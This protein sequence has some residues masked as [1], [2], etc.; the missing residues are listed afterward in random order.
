MSEKVGAVIER[1]AARIKDSHIFFR[2]NIPNKKLWNAV[3]A[4][5]NGA[6]E[7]DVLVLIDNTTFGSAKD[8]AL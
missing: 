3:A 7:A 4:Y 2:P 1:Y 8:G 6:N 5:A